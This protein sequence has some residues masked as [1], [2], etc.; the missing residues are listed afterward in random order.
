MKKMLQRRTGVIMCVIFLLGMLANAEGINITG[1]ETTTTGRT[2]VLS[3][4][5]S[6]MYDSDTVFAEQAKPVLERARLQRES[7]LSSASPDELTKSAANAFM[8]SDIAVALS[9][10]TTVSFDEYAI[11]EKTVRE[12]EHL[13]EQSRVNR[14]IVKYRDNEMMQGG[15]NNSTAISSGLAGVE[16][17]TLDERVNPAE[18]VNELSR[19]G[20]ASQIEYIQPDFEL[21]YASLVLELIP[22]SSVNIEDESLPDDTGEISEQEDEQIESE[23]TARDDVPDGESEELETAEEMNIPMQKNA[24]VAVIDTGIDSTHSMLSEYTIEGWN[25]VSNTSTTYDPSKP[26]AYSH[27]THIAGVIAEAA[28]YY[29]ADMEILPLCVFDDGLA[30]TSTIIEAIAYAD[31]AGAQIVNMSLGGT[32]YNQALYD[33]ISASDA[34]FVC[35]AGNSRSDNMV[36]PVYPASYDLPNVISVGSVNRDDGYSYFS[37]YSNIDVAALGRDVHSAK[38]G[39]GTMPM[40]G[41]SVSAAKVSGTAAVVLS[42][43]DMDSSTLKARLIDS[44]DSLTN[45]YNKVTNGKRVNEY[46]AINAT[47][48][49]TY[50]PSYVDDFDVHGYQRTDEE[51]WRLFSSLEIMQVAVGSYHSVSLA[52]D[53]TVWAWGN[54]SY[55]QLGNGS[56]TKSR[57]PVQV[58]GVNNV[59]SVAVGDD[60]SLVVKNDGTV[61]A[62]GYNYSGQLG[63]GT[64]T[65]RS[66]PVQVSGLTEVVSL[67]G[68]KCH[69]LA[70]KSDGTAWSWGDNSY[71][72][73]GDNTF[74]D[75]NTPVQVSGLTSVIS[76]DGGEHHSIALKSDGTVWSWGL[77][78]YGQLGDGTTTMVEKTIPSQIGFLANIMQISSGTYHNLAL[79]SDG[80]VWSWGRNYSGELGDGTTVNRYTPVQ[81]SGLSSVN[82][83][84]AGYDHCAAVKNDGTVWIWGFNEYGQLAIG[85]TTNQTTPAHV[86][87]VSNAV[88]VSAGFLR[89]TC[90]TNDGKVWAWGRNS[91]G[92]LGDGTTTDRHTPVQI[93]F[94]IASG[95]NLSIEIIENDNITISLIASDIQSFNGKTYTLTYDPAKLQLLDA[96]AQTYG[97]NTTVGAIAGTNSTIVSIS[98]GE[99]VLSVD[100]AIPPGKIWS[101]VITIFVFETLA[102]DTTTVSVE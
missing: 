70:S 94:P 34:L 93:T 89:T 90:I 52:D 72:Q 32:Q 64:T 4:P 8:R 51:N 67:G 66:T 33:V 81:V 9:R 78:N 23:Q 100:K 76:M 43:N 39:G 48:G 11:T 30:Y 75:R 17:I 86:N 25:F 26:Y 69:S 79:K 62:F 38:P 65:N 71:G 68:A 96:A 60:H 98:A 24:L 77:S 27:G 91:G 73:L 21:S 31:N 95:S 58:I 53:G 56:N 42:C 13:Y 28:Q 1:T 14:F 10:V 87:G 99:I 22:E 83:I 84:A 46:N 44:A 55:G 36:V 20:M 92:I 74:T 59:L 18:F 54:N 5:F 40:T 3:G 7:S 41:T 16:I 37:N 85:T 102:T 82:N 57:T 15:I 47:P 80:T 2:N 101:G 97:G 29:D 88:S 63:D 12:L 61:W 6:Q 19:N 35:A 50:T 49:T 45:L